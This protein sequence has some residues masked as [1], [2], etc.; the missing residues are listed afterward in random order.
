MNLKHLTDQVLLIDT[1]KL[2]IQERKLTVQILH[3]LKEIDRRKLYSDMRFSS[4][5]EYCVK[6]LGYS[7][8][9][10]LRRITAARLLKDHP[11]IES[12]IQD[13]SLSL[14][15]LTRANQFFRS[16][17]SNLEEKKDMLTK[18]EGL[19]SKDCERKLFEFNHTV[20]PVKETQKRI[21][22]THS[23]MT[24]VL[25]DKTLERLEEIKSLL[26][27]T[28][29]MDAL[30]SM[31]AEKTILSLKTNKF[32]TL[33]S[34]PPVEV[35]TKRISNSVKREIYLRD[36]KCVICGGIHR[37]NYDHRI[38]KSLGGLNTIDNLRILCS[39]CNQRARIRAKL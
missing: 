22:P 15:N 35:A 1:K 23:R 11:Q 7:E 4:L 10:A 39:N 5:F 21:S 25:S 20:L 38:P 6:E 27:R 36:R 37:L 24:V 12:K 18:I 16:H 2:S 19:S 29:S 3:H 30:I 33:K 8:S 17:E 9:S 32:K 34:P 13:G 14:T 26:N 31:M 28:Y